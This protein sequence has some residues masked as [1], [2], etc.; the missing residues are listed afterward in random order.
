MSGHRK[1]RRFYL[2]A[3]LLSA[4][5]LKVLERIIDTFHY[6]LTL[7]GRCDILS[8]G[9]DSVI[10]E[11]YDEKTQQNSVNVTGGLLSSAGGSLCLV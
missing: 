6:I 11:V 3:V 4:K 9:Y 2:G 5:Y 10:C 8:S 7:H 1:R